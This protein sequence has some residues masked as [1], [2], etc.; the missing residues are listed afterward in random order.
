MSLT[1]DLEYLQTPGRTQEQILGFIGAKLSSI[2]EHLRT[3]FARLN[4]QEK[5]IARIQKN[6]AEK[7]GT[8]LCPPVKD[9]WPLGKIASVAVIVAVAIVTAI[10][11]A[12]KVLGG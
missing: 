3:D 1:D 4:N 10:V 8:G 9:K 6:C 12:V 7:V 11:A 5:S 2:E